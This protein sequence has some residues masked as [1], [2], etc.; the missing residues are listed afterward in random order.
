MSLATADELQLDH[1]SEI[2][3][4]LD[5][6]VGSAVPLQLESPDDLRLALTP[7]RHERDAGLLWLRLPDSL[8]RLPPWLA[9]GSVHAHA[10]LDRVRI[11]FPLG[12]HDLIQ[13]RGSPALRLAVPTQLRRHQRRQNFR[14]PALSQHHPRALL[15][16]GDSTLRLAALDLSSGGMALVWPAGR[17]QP[18]PGELLGPLELELERELRLRLRL[19]VSHVRLR[20]DGS[21]VL[22]CGFEQLDAASERLLAQQLQKLQRR[23][24]VVGR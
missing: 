11:D 1:P 7:L 17:P 18:V 12:R 22:G 8:D 3:A 23:A 15:P 16:S 6:L 9:D 24:R 20:D 4:L 10:L 13:D 5:E 2:A 19:R 21:A 14:V